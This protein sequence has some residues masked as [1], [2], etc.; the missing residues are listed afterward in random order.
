M[1]AD[2]FFAEDFALG[3]GDGGALF[4]DRAVNRCSAHAQRH[5]QSKRS[6]K[7]GQ[8]AREK[9]HAGNNEDKSDLHSEQDEHSDPRGALVAQL[10]EL[11]T[12]RII[13]RRQVSD[14]E[15]NQSY[16]NHAPKVAISTPH[17]GRPIRK[18]S[19]VPV[20]S[21]SKPSTRA[22]ARFFPSRISLNRTGATK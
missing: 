4:E 15:L 22:V 3:E 19:K 20:S 5:K 10:P 9:K 11:E 18:L 16:K 8:P 6:P 17:G 7:P 21:A 12:P 1:L 13:K 2:E 14:R